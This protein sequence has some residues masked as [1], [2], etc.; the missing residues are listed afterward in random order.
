MAKPE[1]AA[2]AR[3]NLRFIMRDP[4][5]GLGDKYKPNYK[6]AALNKRHDQSLIAE[7][8]QQG[9]ELLM[10]DVDGG[11]NGELFVLMGRPKAPGEE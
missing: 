2:G 10:D 1:P 8:A 3:F 5:N 7:R 11:D 9:W 6:Y 4:K